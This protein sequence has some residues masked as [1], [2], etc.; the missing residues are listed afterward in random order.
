[1]NTPIVPAFR[2][3]ITAPETYRAALY[4]FSGFFGSFSFNNSTPQ[5]VTMW[6]SRARSGSGSFS[7]AWTSCG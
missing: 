2:S 5:K 3:R 4:N 1:M 6:R 7:P